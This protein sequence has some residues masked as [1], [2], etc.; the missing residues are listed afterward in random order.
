MSIATRLQPPPALT[1]LTPDTRRLFV[2]G[3]FLPPGVWVVRDTTLV[4]EDA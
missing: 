2:A 3:G 4:L 1:L